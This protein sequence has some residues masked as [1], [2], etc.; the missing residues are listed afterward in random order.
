MIRSFMFLSSYIS[1]AVSVQAAVGQSQDVRFDLPATRRGGPL[2]L[3]QS[4]PVEKAT[5]RPERGNATPKP[6][7]AKDKEQE[8]VLVGDTDEF[9][10]I[11]EANP[12]VDKGEWELE[13]PLAWTTRSNHQ[14]D[15]TTLGLELSYGLTD[16]MYVELEVLPLNF[17]DGGDQGNGDLEL[18]LFNRFVRETDNVPAIAGWASVRLPTGQGSSG[19]DGELHAAVTKTLMPQFRG[20]IEGFVETANG[21]QGA[22][23]RENRRPFQWGAGPGF[24]YQL[25]DRTVLVLNYLNRASEERG[26]H[27]ENVL[28]VGG[29]RQIAPRQ[30]LKAGFEVGLD[31]QPN[32][33]N[34]AFKLQWEIEW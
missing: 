25:D 4:L 2:T 5:V 1:A 7:D 13:I 28:Q 22:E 8:P 31:G 11:R 9:F 10:N 18:T 23:E 26:S 30:I 27:N 24:D 12:R 14:R 21:G 15:D 20:H 34:F 33:R 6:N 19:V 16:D 17:G 3:A 32:T 29:Y